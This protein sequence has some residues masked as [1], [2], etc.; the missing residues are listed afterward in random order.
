MNPVLKE[1]QSQVTAKPILDDMRITPLHQID[2]I[3]RPEGS[4]NV[5]PTTIV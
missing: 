3:T 4:I 5:L 2:T 1:I